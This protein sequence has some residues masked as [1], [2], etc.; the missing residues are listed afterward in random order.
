MAPTRWKSWSFCETY[1]ASSI[2]VNIEGNYILFI[3]NIIFATRL[4]LCTS[5]FLKFNLFHWLQARTWRTKLN[6]SDPEWSLPLL[7]LPAA[8][9]RQVCQSGVTI[10]EGRTQHQHWF[11]HRHLISS[12]L[13]ILFSA[14]GPASCW[15]WSPC[16]CQSFWR[17]QQIGTYASSLGS[18]ARAGIE[19]V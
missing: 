15:W 19:T 13:F 1:R 14:C 18:A 10:P 16:G 4:F 2:E 7:Y 9:V 17:L 3:F 8:V 6:M 11:N 5:V 12:S